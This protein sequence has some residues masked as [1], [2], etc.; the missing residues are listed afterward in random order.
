[1]GNYVV[2]ICGGPRDGE[3]LMEARN[4]NAALAAKRNAEWYMDLLEGETIGID[5]DDG[6]LPIGG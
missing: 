3:V 4:L 1:M 2:F 5:T 6:P